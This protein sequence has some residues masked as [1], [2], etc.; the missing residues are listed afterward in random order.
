MLHHS[1]W[2]LVPDTDIGLIPHLSQ[3]TC[4]CLKRGPIITLHHSKL[5]SLCRGYTRAV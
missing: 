5:G 1:T 4:Q 2:A 3:V